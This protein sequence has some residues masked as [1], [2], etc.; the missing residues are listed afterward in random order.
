MDLESQ[1]L[2]PDVI[3]FFENRID[4]VP[5]MEALMLLWESRATRWNSDQIA[6]R[7]YVSIENATSILEDLAGRR[8]IRA[9]NDGEVT[10]YEYDDAW[11]KSGALMPNVATAYRRQLVQVT[12]LIHSKTST[13]VRD[14]ARAFRLKRD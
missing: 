11:D 6:A 3:Q 12:I 9:E 10:T 13:A 4:S 1:D 8:L 7:L 5:H 2:L 14:F